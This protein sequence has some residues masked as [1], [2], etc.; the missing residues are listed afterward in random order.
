GQQPRLV[1][2]TEGRHLVD[3]EAGERGP[4]RRALAQDGQPRQAGLER[5]QGQPLVQ[6]VVGAH[7]P[8]PLLV[9][10]CDVLRRA[11]RP[12]AP[13]PPVRPDNK[14]GHGSTPV[15]TSRANRRSA[16]VRLTFEPGQSTG[17][18]SRPTTPAGSWNHSCQT[19]W[20][21]PPSIGVARMMP[22]PRRIFPVCTTRTS[23]GGSSRTTCMTSRSTAGPTVVTASIVLP[24]PPSPATIRTWVN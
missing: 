8:A 11:A 17:Q 24:S 1:V 4:E 16:W 18:A 14:I 9:V 7:R 2:R 10:V 6:A 21:R 20:V 19:T 15:S 22:G 3:R 12:A 23:Y 5:L 13:R